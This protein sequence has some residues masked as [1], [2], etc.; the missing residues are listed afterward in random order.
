MNVSLNELR[1][2]EMPAG[3]RG[4]GWEVDVSLYMCVL[5]FAG[6]CTPVLCVCVHVRA[7]ASVFIKASA[8]AETGFSSLL[9]SRL[10]SVGLQGH[11]CP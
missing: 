2:R 7:R 11:R 10:F 5:V 6:V 8:A 4:G 1:R 3:D 9:C